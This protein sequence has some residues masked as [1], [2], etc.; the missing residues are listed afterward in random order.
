MAEYVMK[1]RE[2]EEN[3]GWELK[4]EIKLHVNERLYRAG[5]ISEE[6]YEAAKLKIV[7]GK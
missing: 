2:T 6:I 5:V 3:S 4:Q 1:S 7:N